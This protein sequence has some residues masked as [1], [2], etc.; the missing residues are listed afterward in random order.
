MKFCGFSHA[1]RMSWHIFVTSVIIQISPVLRLGQQLVFTATGGQCKTLKLGSGEALQ[2]CH[3]NC[4]LLLNPHQF[5]FVFFISN[6]YLPL[7]PTCKCFVSRS[8]QSEVN[9]FITL[10]IRQQISACNQFFA[11]RHDRIFGLDQLGM[12]ILFWAM[13]Q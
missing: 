12:W 2:L 9:Y 1:D 8:S 3:S 11:K 4:R 6:I 7:S 10:G 13:D 5:Y